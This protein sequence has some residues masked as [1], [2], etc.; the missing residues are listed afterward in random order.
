VKSKLLDFFPVPKSLAMHA[1][2][3]AIT[4]DAIQFARFAYKKKTEVESYGEVAVPEHVIDGGGVVEEKEFIQIL[5]KIKD[6][7]KLDLVDVSI[8]EEKSYLFKTVVLG[9]SPKEIKSNIELKI[10]ENVPFKLSEVVFDFSI[11]EEDAQKKER[12][13]VVSVLPRTVVDQYLSVFHESGLVPVSFQV[14]SQAVTGAAVPRTNKG[15]VLVVHIKDDKAS[16]Y[17]V[18][19]QTVRFSSTVD[20]DT[21][22]TRVNVLSENIDLTEEKKDDDAT[23]GS[24]DMKTLVREV[25]KIITYW[26]SH[27]GSDEAQ[28][29]QHIYLTGT[30]DEEIKLTDYMSTN[31]S[32]PVE[33]S[34][35]WQNAFS[36]NT[37]I[38]NMKR[39]DSLRFAAAIGLALP[40]QE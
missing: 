2:G 40:N 13:V 17:V 30:I 26:K 3:L 6:Q 39:R 14:E 28:A 8:P 34:N 7:Y 33:V 31:I 35:V 11:L 29:I 21:F 36:F 12:E 23:Q 4:D 5:K 22:D 38:P 18:S 24:F 37:T 15:T 16:F 9:D 32:L 25:R 10:Q 19:G 27:D 20:I 1:S